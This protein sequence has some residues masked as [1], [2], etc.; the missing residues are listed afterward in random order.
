MLKK[1][2][3]FQTCQQISSSLTNTHCL[4]S[5][6]NVLIQ[7]LCFTWTSSNTISVVYLLKHNAFTE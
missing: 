6:F 4:T 5:V 3:L 2:I 1:K 7:E